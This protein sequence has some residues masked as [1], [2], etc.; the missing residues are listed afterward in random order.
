MNTRRLIL[1]ALCLLCAVTGLEAE[2]TLRKH[3][4]ADTVVY[5]HW[6]G[7][8]L[9]FDG[10]YLGQMLQEPAVA[11][12]LG[13]G[14]EKLTAEIPPGTMR[15]AANN[16]WTM[17]GL[18]W[19]N[20]VTLGVCLPDSKDAP[21]TLYLLADLGQDAEDFSKAYQTL[22]DGLK[23]DEDLREMISQQ[24]IN[25]LDVTVF[26][27]DE[28]TT[29][30]MAMK[31]SVWMLSAGQAT[32]ET[33]LKPGKSLDTNETFT[34]CMKELGGENLQCVWWADAKAFIAFAEKVE[35]ADSPPHVEA[36]ADGANNG[37]PAEA[38]ISETRKSLA[39]LGY[40]RMTALAGTMR[41]VDKGILTT[42]RV[43]SPAP[44]H[45]LLKLY[46]GAPLTQA[47]LAE[48]PQ[49]SMF[50]LVA[51]L[52]ATEVYEEI[53]RIMS[54][55]EPGSEKQLQQMEQMVLKQFEVDIR[56]ELLASLGDT[57]TVTMAPSIGGPLTGTVLSVDVKDEDTLRRSIARLE[58]AMMAMTNPP[59]PPDAPEEEKRRMEH[60]RRHAPRIETV[61]Y[62][63]AVV[64]YLRVPQPRV[65]VLPAWSIHEGKL[66]IALWPQV[67]SSALQKPARPITANEEFQAIRGRLAES[68][69]MC[70]YANGEYVTKLIYPLY[71][72]GGTAASN[73]ILQQFGVEGDATLPLLPGSLPGMLKYVRP[74]MGVITADEKGVTKQSFST[75]IP[76]SSIVVPLTVSMLMPSLVEARSQAKQ[77]SS[78]AKLRSIAMVAIIYQ[79]EHDMYPSSLD[80]LNTT[81]NL[82][83][84][85]LVSPVS[86][87]TPPRW[88]PEK[89]RFVG[90]V[91]YILL[92]Y[93]KV[94]QAKLNH[95]LILVYEDPTNYN[96]K[97][98]Q[99]AFLDG[100]VEEI[101]IDRFRRLL[102]ESQA[103]ISGKAAGDEDF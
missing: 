87:K 84:K 13:F 39:A 58:S 22:L 62:G 23:S 70:S 88:D 89:K 35:Q 102:K 54:I 28:E 38:P 26:Q 25:G 17:G 68:A 49:D 51:N 98:T 19:Q 12:L 57:W 93:S 37:E 67:I 11:E 47:D 77:V 101:S 65:P 79:H 52:S 32:I 73:A 64:H 95:H 41:I 18:L 60:K 3:L 86:G 53:I 20:P 63:D 83:P 33:L 99:V 96:N 42:T 9:T 72:V 92:D 5:A 69:G 81:G 80:D 61:E 97:F 31:G 74:Q 100:H 21:P 94:D 45:G 55:M 85:A 30:Q 44:H 91:D 4:P 24:Q 48:I 59:I 76:T 7:R 75:G 103:V 34:A 2:D 15:Q 46:T 43:Y 27:P 8:S 6:A 90:P 16:A 14:F 82:S 29:F 50:A 66:R 40:D 71:L 10:S 1:A 36:P 78:M 56:K